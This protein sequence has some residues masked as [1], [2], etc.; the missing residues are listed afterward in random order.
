MEFRVLG[1]LEVRSDGGRPAQ[2]TR[3]K[4][5][6]LLGMLCLHGNQVVPTGTVVDWLW[7]ESPPSSA[8]ANLQSYVSDLRKIVGRER[9]RTGRDGYLLQVAESELD[10]ARFQ[11]LAGE[12]KAASR[13]GRAVVAVQNLSQAL[14]LWR[15]DVLSGLALP[16]SGRAEVARLDELRLAAEEDHIDARLALGMHHDAVADLRTLIDKHPLRERLWAQYALAL[17]RCGRQAEALQAHRDVHDLL[18]RELGVRPGAALR[19]LHQRMLR[20]D[21]E[22]DLRPAA[23]VVTVPRQLPAAVCGFTGRDTELAVLDSLLGRTP[24][25]LVT[26]AP[27]VGKTALALHWAHQ[28]RDRFPDGHLHARL[29]AGAEPIDVLGRFLRALGV[30][31]ERV[32]TDVDEAASTAR[33]LLADRKILVLLD[34]ACSAEQVRP[35]LPAGDGCFVLVTSRDRLNGLVVAEGARRVTLDVLPER[36]AMALLATSLGDERVAAEPEAVAELAELCAHLPL[37]LRITAANLAN[38]PFRSLADGVRDLMASRLSSL[39]VPG[40]DD[41]AVRRAFDLSY[42]ALAPDAQRLFRLLG[43]LPGPVFPVESAA[44]LMGVS[45]AEVRP[46][47]DQ[48][49]TAHLIG[50]AD[51]DRYGVHDLLRLYAAEIAHATDSA[52]D[53]AAA[54]RSLGDAYVTAVECAAV[55]IASTDHEERDRATAWIDGELANLVVIAEQASHAGHP[56]GARRIAECLSGYFWLSRPVS[57]WLKLATIAE[58]NAERTGDQRALASARRLLGEARHCTG[59]NEQAVWHLESA[60]ALARDS[61]WREAEAANLMFLGL[62]QQDRGDLSVAD[63]HF[64]DCLYIARSTS[65]RLMEAGATGNLG[66]I[67]QLTGEHDQAARHYQR[68]LALYGEVDPLLAASAYNMLALLHQENGRLGPALEHVSQALS[69]CERFDRGVEAHAL[70]TLARVQRDT[71]E[72]DD[73]RRTARRSADL[74][75]QLA[76]LRAE[77]DALNTL[78]SI[79][80]SAG[81]SRE[82]LAHHENALA[83]AQRTGVRLQRLESMLGTAQADLVLGDTGAAQ[84]LLDDVVR[85]AT[86]AGFTVLA[87]IARALVPVN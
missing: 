26:G 72:L 23:P 56:D 5:R 33:T 16:D 80:R 4:Q 20:A 38:L 36:D 31:A 15:D 52:E 51:R 85:G 8:R 45:T 27:G 6:L 2:P 79:E 73:A 29:G 58:A 43:L 1:Q 67:R 82:A 83:L 44:A 66:Y 62:V 39:Q 49:A 75:W 60:L 3:R 32:P 35:L 46:V 53:R 14:A 54:T 87:R 59:D 76:D 17:Y 81:R 7:G 65:D 28:V 61:G 48:L 78:G 70:D 18:D 68:A 34:D 64:H 55:G 50:Q 71:G 42:R 19:E 11:R 40:S 86:E 9:L 69:L 37:A 63:Y 12:G 41:L 21:P 13:A 24:I 25:G 84:D 74:A 22:L 77:T 10:S 47:L 30:A 57:D